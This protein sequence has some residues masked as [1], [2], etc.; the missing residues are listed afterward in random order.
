[1]VDYLTADGTAIAPADYTAA[2]GTVT[3]A[4]GQVSRPVAITVRG[5]TLDELDESFAVNLSVPDERVHRRQPGR[6]DDRR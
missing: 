3:F 2:S 1:M 5:D 4:A 6:R